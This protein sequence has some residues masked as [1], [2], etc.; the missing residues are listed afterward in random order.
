MTG[1]SGG[2]FRSFTGAGAAA[3]V[4]GVKV[5]VGSPEFMHERGIDI[6]RLKAEIERMQS[7][8]KTAV[9]VATESEAWGVLGIADTVRT[10]AKEAVVRLRSLGIRQPVML[11]GDNERTAAAIAAEVGVAHYFAY[12]S[13]EDKSTKVAELQNRFGH[14][15]MVGDGVNDAPALAAASVGIA[16]GTAGSDVALETADVAL[17]AD[18]LSKLV[19]AVRVGRRTRTVVRQN[20]GLSLAILA[21]LVPGAVVGWLSLPVAVLAHEISELFVIL[22]GV[23]L[24]RG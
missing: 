4:D 10:Q 11:T 21:I 19:E 13:P 17:M 23:R 5:F 14:V 15:A 6:A 16:M 7:E 9:V 2:D 3:S 20:V 8:A 18:D 1:E 24:A 12:L 22:N